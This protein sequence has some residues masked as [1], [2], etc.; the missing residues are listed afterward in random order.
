L[1]PDHS[2]PNILPTS[3]RG[4]PVRSS[5]RTKTDVAAK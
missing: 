1:Q 4:S 3:S 2:S 5:A